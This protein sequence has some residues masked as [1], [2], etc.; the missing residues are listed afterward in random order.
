MTRLVPGK[1]GLKHQVPGN[2]FDVHRD[3]ARSDF[4]VTHAVAADFSY[5]LPFRAGFKASSAVANVWTLDG[6]VTFQTGMP[7][8]IRAPNQ[9]LKV[10]SVFQLG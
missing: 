10:G 1:G 5:P 9:F 8:A 3:W 2:P 4:D 6:I 7:F